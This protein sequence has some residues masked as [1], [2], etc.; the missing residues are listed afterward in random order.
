MAKHVDL[1]GLEIK[2]AL[3]N[4]PF[5]SKDILEIGCGDGRLT[6][7]YARKAHRVVA[8]D[9]SAASIETASRNTPKSLASKLI[10]RVGRGEELGDYQAKSFDVVFFTWS[11]CCTSIP[12]MGRAL[13]EAWRVL[14]RDGV[15]VNIQPSLHQPFRSGALT[16]LVKGKFGTTVDDERYRQSRLALKYKSLVEGRFELLGEEE[17][18]V[19]T[20]YDTVEDV[21]DD[22]KCGARE[23]YDSLDEKTKRRIHDELASRRT[24]GSIIM[25]E[26]AVLTV[27]RK[28]ESRTQPLRKGRTVG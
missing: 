3:R 16:Y 2:T 6:F 26:N 11:L 5:E 9:P 10:F 22:L 28:Q 21:I 24:G 12:V 25:I 23:Q 4:A 14:R 1:K 27:L 15:L 19:K 18:P 17:F 7:K 13:D 8:V 20:A